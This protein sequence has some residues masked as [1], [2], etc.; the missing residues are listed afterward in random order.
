MFDVLND[1]PSTY[2]NPFAFIASMIDLNSVWFNVWNKLFA[3]KVAKKIQ[4]QTLS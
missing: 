4:L 2:P 3:I 1:L